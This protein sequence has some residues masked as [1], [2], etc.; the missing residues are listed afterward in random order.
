MKISDRFVLRDVCGD[1]IL[2]PLGEKSREYNGVFSLSETGAFIIRS[3]S[4]GRDV[5]D[6]AELL[7]REFDID[8]ETALEDTRAFAQNLRDFGILID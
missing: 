2:V 1:Y 7:S 4:E 3:I 6:T 8:R 5:D